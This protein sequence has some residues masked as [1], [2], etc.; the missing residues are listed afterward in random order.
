[1]N[2]AP[3]LLTLLAVM[4][5]ASSAY[6]QDDWDDDGWDDDPWSEEVSPFSLHGFLEGAAGFRLQ[7]DPALD[8]DMPLGEVRLQLEGK[9]QGERASF[10]F[11]A[12]GVAD[13][14]LEEVDIDVREAMVNFGIG[15]HFDVRAGR[16]ILTWG[17]GDLLF[18]NDLFPKD[19]VSFLS[20]RDNEYLKAPSDALRVSWF[21]DAF[22]V[23]T[24]V[25][26]RFEADRFLTGERLSYF[27][28]ARG[29]TV[30]APPRFRGRKPE[31]DL[32]NA[33]IAMRIY[34]L[35]GS[36]EWAIYGH[37]GFFSQPTAFD[38]AT[39]D[40]TFARMNS[41]G[42]SL[43]GPLRGGLYN[44]E[45]SWYDAS[46][47]RDGTDPNIP[48]SELRFLA[49]YERELITNLTLGT[50]YY[51][52]WL[53]DYGALERNW[54]F[55]PELRPDERRHVVTVR[56]TWRLMRDNLVLGMMNFYA[57]SDD[58]YFLRPTVQYRY[59][60]NL[61][62]N[63]GINLFGGSEESTFYGQFEHN[64]SLF[65]RARYSF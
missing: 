29:R 52:E 31:S 35:A 45:T 30:A 63:A 33:E 38:P 50:Q 54:P 6:S 40:F 9:Y 23:D 49:G 65:A 2:R 19:W 27:D 12:D 11:K 46:H 51:L 21:G 41:V 62:F 22:N 3:T 8:E 42:A 5:F 48:N 13:S 18:L 20:G 56:L 61:Q 47:D 16:Q 39:G 1:M 60:D 7:S 58:D 44:L 32:E 53:Q 57:P 37:R 64:S 59:N 24:A 10:Q 34:G 17:T 26:P 15:E 43:R 55:D 4:M 28:P 14:V 36:Q 25:T